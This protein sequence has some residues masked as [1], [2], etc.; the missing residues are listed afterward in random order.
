MR[1]C[2]LL[3]IATSAQASEYHWENKKVIGHQLHDALEDNG[4]SVSTVITMKNGDGV[5]VFKNNETRNPQSVIDAY[6]YES[7]KQKAERQKNTAASLLGTLD[8]EA[9]TPFQIAVVKI[10]K[11]FAL[12]LLGVT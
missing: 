10:L 4:Y 8:R 9:A 11:L 1:W 12:I 5:I 7:S 6:V 2:L 3:F